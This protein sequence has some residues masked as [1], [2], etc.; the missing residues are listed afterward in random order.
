M[1]NQFQQSFLH[2]KEYFIKNILIEYQ[3]EMVRT[4]IVK[5]YMSVI[6]A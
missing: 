2:K 3:N 5:N 6:P 1:E 4:S